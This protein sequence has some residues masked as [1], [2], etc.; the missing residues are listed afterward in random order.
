[1]PNASKGG[2]HGGGLRHARRKANAGQREPD[3]YEFSVSPT[4]LRNQRQRI[5]KLQAREAAKRT[6][7]ELIARM[8]SEMRELREQHRTRCAAK[9][10]GTD[11]PRMFLCDTTGNKR[12]TPNYALV[13]ANTACTTISI[14]KQ[15]MHRPSGS[16]Q[17]E[18]VGFTDIGRGRKRLSVVEQ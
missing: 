10:K 8:H 3:V 11:K 7:L 1:M 5:R 13:Q 16:V 14:Q 15:Y 12:K 17:Q 4:S 18:L 6:L 9:H 2:K